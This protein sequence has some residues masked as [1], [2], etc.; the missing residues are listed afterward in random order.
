MSEQGNVSRGSRFVRFFAWLVRSIQRP[1]WRR[2]A[3]LAAA[4][5]LFLVLAAF[6]RRGVDYRRDPSALVPRDVGAYFETRR[7][8]ALLS[9]AAE[10]PL[11]S[12]DHRKTESDQWNHLQSFVADLVGGKVH[13]L[14]SQLPLTWFGGAR[15]AAVAW[16]EAGEDS[17][18]A[19]A[20]YLDVPYPVGAIGE[21]RGEPGV[22]KTQY[23][24][25]PN[26]FIVSGNDNSSLAVRALDTWL[27]IASDPELPLHAD[28]LRRRPGRSLASSGMLPE[29]RDKTAVRGVFSPS[30]VVREVFGGVLATV[31]ARMRDD[32]WYALSVGAAGEGAVEVRFTP[33]VAA[34]ASGG[35]VIWSFVKLVLWIV[36]VFCLLTAASILLV[37]LGW[38]GWLKA[39][40]LKAGITPAPAPKEVEPS[41]A[42]REDAGA[43]PPDAAADADDGAD[44]DSPED[45]GLS[46]TDADDGADDATTV[47]MGEEPVETFPEMQEEP[48]GPEVGHLPASDESPAVEAPKPKPAAKSAAAKPKRGAPRRKKPAEA[49]SEP[50]AK[51]KPKRPVRRKKPEA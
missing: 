49:E 21:L 6:L 7:L 45:A 27:I 25:M 22:E 38:G 32:A 30:P 44:D 23:E 37:M 9:G 10:W 11:W 26:F 19:W 40:A 16:M 13:G 28:E 24:D 47:D 3:I 42:F 4:V 31:A 29:W 41:A 18:E 46:E 1:G 5:L 50:E 12:D 2:W 51:P 48:P 15:R 20:I 8:G 33:A 39:L 35:N 43:S 17:P 34:S 36:A 14:G